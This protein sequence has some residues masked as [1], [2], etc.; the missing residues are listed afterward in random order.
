MDEK[1]CFDCVYNSTDSN[2]ND[3][4]GYDGHEIKDIFNTFHEECEHFAGVYD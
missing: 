2:G 3:Y 1:C 4:C